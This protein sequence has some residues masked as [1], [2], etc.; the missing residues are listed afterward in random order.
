MLKLHL[1]RLETSEGTIYVNFGYG[2]IPYN[3]EDVKETGIEVP[4]DCKNYEEIRVMAE[5]SQVTRLKVFKSIK[6]VDVTAIN[7]TYP[8]GCTYT[9]YPQCE[10]PND[11]FP[12][13]KWELINFDGAFFRSEGTN[14]NSFIEEG[15][16]L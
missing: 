7:S 4:E 3:L 13:T 5:G 15:S 1:R 12:F 11:L 10:E 14:A 16:E 2:W 6:V 9:Q 8:V